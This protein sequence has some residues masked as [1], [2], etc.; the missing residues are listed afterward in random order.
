MLDSPAHLTVLVEHLQYSCNTKRDGLTLEDKPGLMGF[1]GLDFEKQLNKLKGWAEASPARM[2]SVHHWVQERTKARAASERRVAEER[3]HEET[4][5]REQEVA[6]QRERQIQT[7]LRRQEQVARA[8]Y[9]EKI[10]TARATCNQAMTHFM[11]HETDMVVFL[12]WMINEI[13]TGQEDMSVRLEIVDMLRKKEV[14]DQHNA[15]RLWLFSS[16]SNLF[17]LARW[18]KSRPVRVQ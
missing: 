18:F 16:V 5:R 10:D 7:E 3:A 8:K 4:W 11:R 13:D 12:N 15:L 1:Y 14:Q 2:D 9:D 6:H 17:P